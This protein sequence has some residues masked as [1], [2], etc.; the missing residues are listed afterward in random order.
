LLNLCVLLSSF[1]A[2][3]V[4]MDVPGANPHLP[5]VERLPGA[6]SPPLPPATPVEDERE[7]K[8]F[9]SPL[10]PVVLSSRTWL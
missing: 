3:C 1:G 5:S 8:D 9:G 4:L 6:V 7:L 2:Y 10:V